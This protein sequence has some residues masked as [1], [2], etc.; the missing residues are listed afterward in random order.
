MHALAGTRE[1]CG[2]A[3]SFTPGGAARAPLSRNLGAIDSMN[4]K[5]WQVALKRRL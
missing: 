3:Y 5:S 2:P 1:G 4:E